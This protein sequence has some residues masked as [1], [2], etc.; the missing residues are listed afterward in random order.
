MVKI[1]KANPKEAKTH[2]SALVKP[3]IPLIRPEKDELD[4]LEYIDHTCHN[5][6]RD[7]NSANNVLKIPRFDFDTLVGQNITTG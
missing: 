2:S 5:T 6:T 7:T 1:E 3:I 4:A